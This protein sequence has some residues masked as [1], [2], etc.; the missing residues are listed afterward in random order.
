MKTANFLENNVAKSGKS[1]YQFLVLFFSIAIKVTKFENN[2][3][4]TPSIYDNRLAG[5]GTSI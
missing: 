3:L 2:N 1:R 5:P 4:P